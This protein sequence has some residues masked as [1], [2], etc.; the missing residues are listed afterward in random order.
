MT[1]HA[2]NINHFKYL[3]EYKGHHL[4]PIGSSVV[5]WIHKPEHTNIFTEGY[6]GITNKQV[7]KRWYKHKLDAR[8]DGSLPIHRAINKYDDIIFEV[9]LAADNR[10]YCQ[11]IEK[12]LRPTINIGWNVAQGGDIVNTYEGGLANRKRIEWLNLNDPI[13]INRLAMGI[14]KR[15][16]QEA[17]V[18]A[19]R[20]NAYAKIVKRNII[21]SVVGKNKSIMNK[22]RKFDPRNKHGLP[23]CSLHPCGKWRAQFKGKGLGY[24][25]TKE[26]AHQAYLEAKS[27]YTANLLNMLN[28]LGVL[29]ESHPARACPGVRAP[30]LHPSPR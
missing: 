2:T 28:N 6:V 8:E 29:N 21:E 16:E 23:G 18:Y 22:E 1:K 24:Y 30:R 13:T 19:K 3:K 10:E 17:N 25:Y 5:Y 14:A 11:D 27:S 12:K 26:E 9:I 20:C 4:Q 7:S 15:R